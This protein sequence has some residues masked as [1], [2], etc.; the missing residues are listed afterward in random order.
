MVKITKP[1]GAAG[2]FSGP[3]KLTSNHVVV[4]MF[5]VA[6][7]VFVPSLILVGKLTSSAADEGID[8][9]TN[10]DHFGRGIPVPKKNIRRIVKTMAVSAVD[11]ALNEKAARQQQANPKKFYH[12]QKSYATY[13]GFKGPGTVQCGAH[14]APTC[15][16]CP[17]GNGAAWCNGQ[18]EW[19]DGA[20]ARSSKLA[21]LH[22]DY[23]R[24]VDRY[25]FQQVVNQRDEHVNV[26]VVR[27]PFRQSDDEDVYNFYKDDILFIGISSFEAYP[28]TSPNPF[29]AKFKSEY[30]LNMFPGFL[31][32]MHHPSQF[33]PPN[34]ETMLMAQSDF[35]LDQP[36]KYYQ[37]HS[38]VEKIYD[39]VYSGG[40]QDVE[41]DCKGWASYNKNFSFVREAL[42]FMCSDEYNVTGVLIANKN[43]DGTKTCTI[44]KACEGKMVQSTF[45]TQDKFFDYLAKARW[46]FLPQVCDAS[47]RVSTQALSMN[48]P[49]LMNR[50]ILGGWKYMREGETGE[51][52]HDMS[53]FRQ[54]LRR[55]LD[56]TRGKDSQYR[57]LDFVKNNYGNANS[58]PRFLEFVLKHWGDRI[59]FPVGTTGLM[60]TGA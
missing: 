6:M 56:N 26:I 12:G 21:H 33:F 3:V 37:E 25:A 1:V 20:C 24:I 44:P 5:L 50:N 38:D 53:D 32:N 29:S 15:A 9:P 22:P 45:L 13:P 23:F 41:N 46:A 8:A 7:F 10:D 52:F 31:H 34:V 36:Q 40:D 39:F 43:K 49:L 17:Q 27:A 30:Y 60:P 11:E 47:P 2:L 59:T 35:M 19:Q 51:F 28:L 57:P 4:A 55:I 16:D 42:E 18:C 58:G 48:V 14:K 54:S